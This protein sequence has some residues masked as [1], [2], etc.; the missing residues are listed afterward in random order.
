MAF[1]GISGIVLL[2]VAAFYTHDALQLFSEKRYISTNLIL[3]SIGT[4]LVGV[5]LLATGVILYS[6]KAIL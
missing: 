1:Y 6:I 4:S 2:A 5:V 3:I